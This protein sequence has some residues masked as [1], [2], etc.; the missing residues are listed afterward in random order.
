MVELIKVEAFAVNEVRCYELNE[1]T[2]HWPPERTMFELEMF[3]TLKAALTSWRKIFQKYDA[4]TLKK[5][6]YIVKGKQ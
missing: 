6:E 3:I 1:S 5:G 2:Q 4:D